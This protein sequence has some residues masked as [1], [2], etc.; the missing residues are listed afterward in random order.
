MMTN[1]HDLCRGCSDQPTGITA[2]IHEL[3]KKLGYKL[4]C[5]PY[6]EFNPKEKLITRVQYLNQKF[7]MLD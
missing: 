1:Y 7:K 6:N 3:V 2:L 4:L 5:V